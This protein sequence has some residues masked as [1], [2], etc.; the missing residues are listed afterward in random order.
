MN[1]LLNRYSSLLICVALALATLAV[2]WQ[3]CNYDFIKYDDDVYVTDNYHV[4]SGLSVPNIRW[5]F[6]T[7]HAGNWLP[8][9]W[10]SFM[11]DCQLF[12]PNP[13]WMHL[14]NLLLHIA[15]TLLLFA[16]LKKMTG[17][18]WPSAFVAA[19]FALHPLHV[20]SV[21]WIT[22]RKDVLSTL[23]LLLTLAAY[24]SYVRHRGMVRYLL[25][26]LLFAS[27][28]LAKPMLVTLPFL[29]LLLDYWPL[30]RFAVPRAVKT[31]AIPDRRRVL[32][33]IIIEKI[34]FFVLSAVSSVITF[35]VQKG[36]GAVLDVNTLS[37][38]KGVA[39]AFL[40]Y[41]KYIGKMFWPQN[42]AVF[43][44]LDIADIP[45]WQIVLCVLLLLVISIFAVR[46]GRKH[47][48]LPVG[49]FW[50]VGT[51]IPV[52]GLVQSGAQSLADRYTYISLTG[53][54]IIIAFGADRL[55]AKWNYRK[56]FLSLLAAV[57]LGAASVCTSLQLKFWQNSITLFQRAVDV[58]SNNFL[59]YNNFANV[60]GKMGK[61]NQSL[62]YLNKALALRPNS[63]EI[64][65]NL[66]NAF[67][68]L[69]KVDQAI[70]HYKEAVK[71]KPD[72]ADAHFNFGVAL[73][74]K[75][76]FNEAVAEYQKALAI[77]PV[78]SDALSEFGFIY[79][80]QGK[81]DQA[82]DCYN[83]AIV[84][85]PD[86]IIAHGRLGLALAEQGKFDDAIREFR[87][88][89]KA[90]PDDV[91]MYCNL[92]ILLER[93]NKTDQAI[94]Q[95]HRALQIKPDDSKAR[96]LL[97]AALVKDENKK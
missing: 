18:L 49:W 76:N 17:S 23:F 36:S 20:E 10:L 61:L 12:G 89:L 80:Q 72:L 19:L 44:P 69:G 52:I 16:V 55:T 56:Y 74:K 66:G 60:L 94:E 88:V 68:E 79:A 5:A 2:Y 85:E 9:T 63:A 53:L 78:N 38:Q 96:K 57:V 70:E 32:Y 62:E 50:F 75:G 91:E 30:E 15:N 47:R 45:L 65:N 87:T 35:I 13:G 6:T 41:A 77:D 82:V 7:P 90:R 1:K 8:L 25:T 81:L 31:A 59:I 11:L 21:A 71:Y 27:G 97:D 51:L 26:V 84:I 46:F 93:Q 92:G 42:L 40:S 64:H 43:Y 58:T 24:V 83:K 86:N 14:V 29:L 73:S 54:F 33:R 4:T 67:R 3:V 39:N 34:P 37:L 48:Y 22:E 28:L 95:Y